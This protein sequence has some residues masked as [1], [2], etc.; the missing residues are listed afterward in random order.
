VADLFILI[1]VAWF[2]PCV[3][4]LVASG[5]WREPRALALVAA[6]SVAL[7]ANLLAVSLAPGL[8]PEASRGLNWNWNGKVAAIAITLIVYALLPAAL[9]AEA[10]LFNRPYPPEWR[11]VLLVAGATMLLFWLVSWFTGD[12][13]PVTGETLLF[14][15]TMLGLDEESSFR[16]V[17]L[18]LLVGAFGKPMRIAGIRLGWGALP[19]VAFFGL[20]HTLATLTAPTIDWG[21]FWLTLSLTGATGAALLWLKERTGSIWVPVIVHNLINVGS[22]LVGG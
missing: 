21:E 12:H 18:A 11:S 5:K 9:R 19:V 15:A 17:L 20:A 1:A 3:V 13:A 2:L 16:G 14:Q 6:S 10:G 7:A 22:K 8:F 4:G